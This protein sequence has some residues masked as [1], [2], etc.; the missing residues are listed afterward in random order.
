MKKEK[1]MRM[2]AKMKG[3]IGLTDQSDRRDARRVTARPTGLLNHDWII[4]SLKHLILQT[5]PK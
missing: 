3:L 5:I 2:S 4:G 1:L